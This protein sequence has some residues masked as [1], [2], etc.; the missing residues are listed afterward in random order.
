LTDASQ[1]GG[2]L[3][4]AQV[5]PLVE[6]VPPAR[7]GGTERVVHILTE[8][9]VRRGHQ[10]TL[11]AAG[12]SS[13]TA[14]LV[15]C[16]PKPLWELKPMDPLSYQM[17]EVERVIAES[18]RFD[19]IHTH[20]HFPWL[21][22]PR[23]QAPLLTTMHGRLDTPELREMLS[24]YRGQPLVSISDSQRCP[25]ADLRLNWTATV[26]HG[27]EVN[28]IK[29]GDGS[30]GYLVFLGRMSPEKGPASAIRIASK[31][32]MQLKMATRVNETER[33]FFESKVKPLLGAAEVDLVGEAD[34]DE[35]SELLRNAKA[36]LMPI[37]WEEPFGLVFVEAL[38]C[39][40]PVLARP[41]GAVPEIVEDGVHGFL[42]DS[43]D[44]LAE[45]CKHLD[46]I[47]RQACRRRAETHFSVGV[48][49]D[50]Y[51]RA[52]R[53]VAAAGKAA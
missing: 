46:E 5:A 28:R 13:T 39:G 2:R 11:F 14:E 43:D 19:A 17:L 52:Y 9:L 50:G 53:Q 10:V 24:F 42:R 27:L 21:A 26:H 25:V 35:K 33:E 38:A 48:M 18:D 23:M 3:R 29:P 31:A 37:E 47:D 40:T 49:A 34:D 45:A 15:E 32:G 51:E 30:G 44:E 7:Y 41:Q 12:T 8:E 4:I 6:R 20:D 36:L 16:S 22:A 1:S